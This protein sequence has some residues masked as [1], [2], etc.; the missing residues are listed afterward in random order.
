MFT[1]CILLMVKVCEWLE[2]KTLFS[3]GISVTDLNEVFKTKIQSHLQ[4]FFA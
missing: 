2:G 4:Q 1:P 3:E